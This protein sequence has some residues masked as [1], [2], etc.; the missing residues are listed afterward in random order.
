MRWMAILVVMLAPVFAWAGETLHG[1]VS[2][3]GV[4]LRCGAQTLNISLDNGVLNLQAHGQEVSLTPN[5]QLGDGWTQPQ[6][7]LE[8]PRWERTAGHLQARV[9]Y[10]VA[11]AREFVIEATAYADLEA[12][13]VTSRLRVLDEPRGQYY[14]WQSDLA[15]DR[16]YAPA[17]EGVAETALDKKQWASLPWREWWFL[18]RGA[19]GLAVLP[20]NVAGRAPG[21]AGGV[22]LHALPR[23]SLLDPA[24][25]HDASFGLAW[26][27]DATAARELAAAAW[28][29]DL[30][31]LQ[32]GRLA[33][34][35]ADYGAPAPAWL[36]EAE[37]YN[38]YY[39]D[40]AQWTQ[41]NVRGKLRGFPFIVGSTP[42]KAALDRC[43]AEGVKLLHYVVYTCLLNTELQVREGGRVYSEWSE[44]L[45]NETRD[46]K[47]H[48]DWI[49]IAKDGSIQHDG[50]GQ[51]HGHP[52]LLNTCLHQ[53]G[54][55]EAAVRQVRMLMELGYDG[56]F[57]DLAG[58][59]V[60][61]YGP[62]HG[63]HTHPHPEWT[64]TQ[65]YEDVLRAVYAEVKR[66]GP[67][68]I[69]MQNTCTGI[70]PTH[71]AYCDSQMLEAF[72]Y[73]AE[74]T[75]LR[76]PWPELQW[77]RQR[78][79]EAVAHGKV[80]VILSYFGAGTSEQLRE[81]AL[82]SRAFA[83]MSGFLWADAL[84]LRDLPGVTDFATEL[85]AARLGRPTGECRQSRGAT[86]RVF[87]RG[88]AVVNPNPWPVS[89]A[90]PWPQATTLRD[91]GHGGTIASRHGVLRLDLAPESGRIL[92]LP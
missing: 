12:V 9:T 58:P 20:T 68:R 64:N 14:Y 90:V 8:G 47:D 15:S 55:K 2:G 21:E 26:V 49:C 91:I 74:S 16:Y 81:A 17:P 70:L 30:P 34:R 5:L 92:T 4:V 18:P 51:E 69:V 84:G 35:E 78:W 60:E 79:A 83:A 76:S 38:L 43:H 6:A 57:I 19:G 32:P 27:A 3:R 80:P 53:P 22:F 71:W 61:C 39:R 37:V 46:L 82:L 11:E 89:V 48:P 62:Q 63:K 88:L 87:E 73:G 31:A 67:D 52:G 33:Q 77:H 13:F 40:K 44:S 59:T 42:D 56:V 45:D 75:V 1:E 72:P 85:Y 65:A 54:L 28:R 66:H 25:S 23:S 29:S 24:T 36:R 50:W 7:A 86:Y 41:D 10:P